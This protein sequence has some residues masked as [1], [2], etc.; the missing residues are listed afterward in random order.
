MKG[1]H[2]LCL[3]VCLQ[4]GLP[5]D[6]KCIMLMD[7]WTVNKSMPFLDFVKEKH[8]NIQPLFV[9]ASCTSKAQVQVYLSNSTCNTATALSL[10]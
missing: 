7:C 3:C 8:P 1:L 4:L 2:V 6:Q 5:E 10:L 9:P